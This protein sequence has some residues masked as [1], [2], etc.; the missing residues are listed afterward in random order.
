MPDNEAA[1]REQLSQLLLGANAHVDLLTALKDFPPALYGAKPENAP[2]SAWEL[3]EHMR[4]G[5]RDLWDFSTNPEYEEMK[6]PDDYWPASPAPASEQ[7]W[8]SSV[9]AVEEDMQLFGKLIK[10][11]KSNLYAQ[12]PWGKKNQTLLR[13]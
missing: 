10:N 12:I 5:L 4:I 7:D 13:E 2:H 6:W 11:S 1:L 9:R 3:L 8:D